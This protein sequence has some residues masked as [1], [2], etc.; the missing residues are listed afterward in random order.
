MNTSMKAMMGIL[1]TMMACFILST[2]SLPRMEDDILAL[3]DAF[4]NRHDNYFPKE[5]LG[6]RNGKGHFSISE[7]LTSILDQAKD[8]KSFSSLRFNRKNGNKK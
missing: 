2:A 5:A 7:Q 8:K 4:E 3:L 1:Y 6:L